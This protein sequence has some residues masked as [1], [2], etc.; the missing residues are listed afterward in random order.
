M[1]AYTVT[2]KSMSETTVD[3]SKF[4]AAEHWVTFYD[5]RDNLVGAYS[6]SDVSSVQLAN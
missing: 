4:R 3:A 2:F 6:T 1:A 5:E